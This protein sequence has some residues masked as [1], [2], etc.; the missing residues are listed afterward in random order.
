MCVIVVLFRHDACCKLLLILCFRKSLVSAPEI[1][2]YGLCKLLQP[3][4]KQSPDTDKPTGLSFTSIMCNSVT[5]C[6]F[7]AVTFPRTA[8]CSPRRCTSRGECASSS[9]CPRT[10]STSASGLMRR[11]AQNCF[12]YT[13][14]WWMS[15][16]FLSSPSCVSPQLLFDMDKEIFPMVVQAVVDEGEGELPCIYHSWCSD[17]KA[18]LQN[19]KIKGVSAVFS[20]QNIWA[21]LTFCWRHL[22]R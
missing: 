9:V 12:F 2:C 1:G 14:R 5:V 8:L 17:V 11:W 19:F 22:K 6:V 7:P 10:P 15:S 21:I 3:Y 20:L 16:L 18:E 13:H 4:V